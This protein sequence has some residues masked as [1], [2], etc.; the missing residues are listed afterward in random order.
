MNYLLASPHDLA[1][2]VAE[3]ARTRRLKLGRRQA[4]LAATAGLALSTIQRFE[5]G[6]DVGFEALIKIALALGAESG[7]AALFPEPDMRSLDDLLR[8]QRQR[9]RVRK[10]VP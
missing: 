1:Q 7:V 3:R 9:K 10:P 8:G 5:S 2:L 6:R 4:D